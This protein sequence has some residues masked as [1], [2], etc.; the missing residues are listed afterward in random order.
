MRILQL[1]DPHTE[2]RGRLAYRVA[3]TSSMIYAAVREI[4]ALRHRPDMVIVTGDLASDAKRG[5]YCIFRDAVRQ[6]DVPVFVL[7]GNHDDRKILMEYLAEWCPAEAATLPSL[8]YRI[9]SDEACLLC[10]DTTETGCHHGCFSDREAAWLDARLAENGG[11]LPVLLFMHH[12]PLPVGMGYMDEPFTGIGLLAEVLCRYPGVHLCCG[13]M[14]RAFTAL[15]EGCV[16]AS[17]PS[18]AMQMEIDLSPTG[19]DAFFME[20]PGYALHTIHAGRVITFFGE[21]LHCR[22]DF[23][24]PHA[25]LGLNLED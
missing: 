10:V 15:W 5:G 24:G 18:S 13:H 25:F 11:R 7:P 20:T 2:E 16:V 21:V 1:S 22:T 23:S 14:H 9:P 4:K 12:V 3:D 8:C 6:L 19:G 17:C